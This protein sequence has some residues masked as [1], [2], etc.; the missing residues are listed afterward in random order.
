MADLM[1][2]H[3][4]V[5]SVAQMVVRKVGRWV[6]C[7]VGYLVVSR[8]AAWVA[9]KDF[10]SADLTVDLLGD[11]MAVKK[12]ELTEPLWAGLLAACLAALMAASTALSWVA[13]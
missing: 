5:H 7:L 11:L 10:Q 6:V 13:K 3:W 2:Q 9:L 4:A 12:V 1:V 8:A